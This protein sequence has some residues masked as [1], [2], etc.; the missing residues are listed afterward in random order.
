VERRDQEE[1]GWIACCRRGETRAFAPLIARYERMV[2][3][4][5]RRL[6]VRDDEVDELAQATF[7]T[8]WERLAQ[9][10]ASA[11]FSTW[12]CQIAVNKCR[13]RYRTRRR[14]EAAYGEPPEPEA[15]PDDAPGPEQRLAERELDAQL[16]AALGQL[17]PQDRELIVFKYIEGHDYETIARILGC[18]PQ[19][20]KVRSVRARVTLKEL[21]RQLGVEP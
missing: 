15:M 6:V 1:A 21:L 4:V 20:A 19:A 5:I 18:T 9:Y 13:D 16:Q 12:L 17:K 11:K 7:V 10:T 3:S 14:R 2:R 8:A